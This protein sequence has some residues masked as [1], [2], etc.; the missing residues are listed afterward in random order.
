[1]RGIE[2]FR[3]VSI[4][5]YIPGSSYVHRLTPATKYLWLFALMIPGC[6]AGVGGIALVFA[7]ALAAGALAGI[8]PDF[9]LRGV[10]PALPFFILA[11]FL[12]FLFGFV[13]DGSGVL[14]ALGPFRMTAHRAIALSMAVARTVALMVVLGVFT[15]VT[16][17]G[18]VAHGVEDFL[19]PLSRF[20]L[21]THRLSMV[22]TVTFRFIPIIAIELEAI[23]KAQASRGANF[24]SGKGGPLRK[25]RDYLPLVVPVTV[26]ALER[27]EVLAE[28]I[29][30][31]NYTGVARTRLAFYK[32]IKG[33][34]A[35]R[36][37]A[38]VICAAAFVLGNVS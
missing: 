31:R 5:R 1:M 4:G 19:S 30:A 23:V 2:F 11:A 34:V 24:G 28:A 35:F 25:T 9:L 16:S 6:T 36:F 17:E 22:V 21:S 26:R 32:G 8:K 3:N 7:T 29:E 12:Q 14:F 13:D 37:L 10:K 15:S 18:E 38:P 20:G 27:A 33:E